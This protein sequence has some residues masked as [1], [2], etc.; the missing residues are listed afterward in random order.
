MFVKSNPN[1][2]HLCTSVCALVECKTACSPQTHV[3][4]MCKDMSSTDYSFS[5]VQSEL[6]TKRV[7]FVLRFT[8]CGIRALTVDIHEDYMSLKIQFVK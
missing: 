7:A 2:I 8:D 6:V 1:N 3:F 5:G 4:R